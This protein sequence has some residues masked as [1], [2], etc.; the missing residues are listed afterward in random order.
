MS[1]TLAAA[2]KEAD[3]VVLLLDKMDGRAIDDAQAATLT[4][5]MKLVEGKIV[6]TAQNDPMPTDNAGKQALREQSEAVA[7]FVEIA[8]AVSKLVEAAPSGK[9]KKSETKADARTT[10]HEPPADV[11]DWFKNKK[12]SACLYEFTKN[13]RCEEAYEGYNMLLK[14][15]STSEIAELLYIFGQAS[16]IFPKPENIS[17][18]LS[19]VG[20]AP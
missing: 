16:T 4:K 2:F 11:E 12:L 5:V 15:P 17:I 1:E 13:R 18:S 3:R 7:G 6:T 14:T 8:I 10:G 19:K 9:G 20:T